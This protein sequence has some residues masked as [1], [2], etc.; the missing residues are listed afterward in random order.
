MRSPLFPGDT[1]PLLAWIVKCSL[2]SALNCIPQSV[3]HVEAKHRSRGKFPHVTI[4]F[5]PIVDTMVSSAKM[6]ASPF[7]WSGR[8]LMKIKNS[9]GPSNVPCRIPDFGV[10]HPET[11]LFTQ[12]LWDLF[13]R[14]DENHS[15]DDEDIIDIALSTRHFDFHSKNLRN[16]PSLNFLVFAMTTFKYFARTGIFAFFKFLE[17]FGKRY[18]WKFALFAFRFRKIISV[19]KL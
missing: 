3:A 13:C 19:V 5:F 10:R 9:V 16:P 1:G 2:F 11:L 7:R 17:I 8:S 6:E 14:N 15:S 18:G 4:G 12:T